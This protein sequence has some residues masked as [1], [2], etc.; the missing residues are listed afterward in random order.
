MSINKEWHLA[1]KMPINPT[2]EER[3]NWHLKHSKKCN[4]R[5]MPESIK[6]ELINSG[7]L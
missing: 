7:K 2:K 5:E 1:N 4:C 3:L 6:Q